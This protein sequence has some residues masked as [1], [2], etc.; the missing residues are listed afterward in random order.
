MSQEQMLETEIEIEGIAPSDI[1]VASYISR[2]GSS[3]LLERTSL[4]ESKEIEIE[5]SEVREFKLTSK[6][7]QGL[8]LSQ[9]DIETLKANHVTTAKSW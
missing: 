5:G 1:E 4:V 9:E 2:L 6:L 7:K 8:E 3:I